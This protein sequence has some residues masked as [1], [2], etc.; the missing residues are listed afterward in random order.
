IFS[1]PN[2]SFS[3]PVSSWTTPHSYTLE[4]EA[5]AGAVNESP[6]QGPVTFYI[7]DTAPQNSIQLPNAAYMNSLPSL[8]GTAT[9]NADALPGAQK[10]VYFR[11]KRNDTGQYWDNT[12]TYTASAADC[13]TSVDVTCLAPNVGGLPAN[14]Y[15]VT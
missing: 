12:S 13:V 8:S 4:S 7:D 10:T 15:A 14:N 9:D 11:V 2:W 3:I 6:T 5:T 1:A